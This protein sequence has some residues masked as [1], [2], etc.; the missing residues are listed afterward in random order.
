MAAVLLITSAAGCRVFAPE[1]QRVRG[2]AVW[3]HDSSAVLVLETVYEAR[4]PGRPYW[5]VGVGHRN[6][7]QVAYIAEGGDLETLEEVA[8]WPDE[9]GDD[10][11]GWMQTAAIYW[12]R[13]DNAGTGAERP[14]RLFYTLGDDP[15]VRDLADG[16][17]E[18]LRLPA[19]VVQQYFGDFFGLPGEEVVPSA[20]E[21]LP[22]PDGELTAALYTLAYQADPDSL[23]LSF[24]NYLAFFTADNEFL[25]GHQPDPVRFEYDNFK[26]FLP[27][28]EGSPLA[29]NFGNPEPPAHQRYV[30]V[31][32]WY[33]PYL[34]WHPD[35]RGVYLVALRDPETSDVHEA[36]FVTVDASADP[37]VTASAATELPARP[38]GAPGGAYS[39]AR[40]LLMVEE[41]ESQ[42]PVSL[43]TIEDETWLPF[44]EVPLVDIGDVEY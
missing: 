22:S 21:V 19:A 30:P 10:G 37:P 24:L 32:A 34:Q 33:A 7:R 18:T 26:T 16:L 15:V 36:L 27:S 12:H 6:Y 3:A 42:T 9:A 13:G 39:D 38:V 14:G 28:I 25:G 40:L 11:A 29:D 31:P 4:L 17:S 5:N 44:S 1:T 2:N 35:S 8:A 20:A 43:F 23:V 41:D